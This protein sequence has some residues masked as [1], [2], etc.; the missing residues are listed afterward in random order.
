VKIIKKKPRL[1]ATILMFYLYS[2]YAYGACDLQ[3]W[4]DLF[5]SESKTSKLS[6]LPEVDPSIKK[7]LKSCSTNIV[8]F[9]GVVTSHTEPLDISKRFLMKS[10]PK[11]FAWMKSHNIYYA[12]LAN[13]HTM[14]YGWIGANSMLSL[15]NKHEIGYAG[16]GKTIKEAS[17][18]MVIK[19][20][21]QKVCVFSFSRTFPTIFWATETRPGSARLTSAATV[22]QI[23]GHRASCDTIIAS[24]HWGAEGA[25]KPK[26]YQRDLAKRSLRAGADL[27]IGH[28][29]HTLQG[30]ESFASKAVIYSLG[31]FIFTS[32]GR[33]VSTQG[34]ALQIELK[35]E[36]GIKSFYLSRLEVGP[37]V[38]SVKIS[39]KPL[40][41]TTLAGCEVRENR[42]FCTYPLMKS[43]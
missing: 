9:E 19:T 16:L 13:N 8:N 43:P 3:F 32:Y 39:S 4:G 38:N 6:K 21:G 35:A 14:D 18:P 42:A 22:E 5:I 25:P 27:I 24:F 2:G 30:L 17:A 11:I 26:Q 28:H 20:G 37:H 23:K 10:S 1:S 36:K 41:A 34:A 31:N 40:K 15:F 7:A 29:P 12:G 33:Q